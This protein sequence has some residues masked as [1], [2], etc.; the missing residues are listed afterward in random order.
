MQYFYYILQNTNRDSN[1]IFFSDFRK[2]KKEKCIIGE[3]IQAVLGIQQRTG[4][5]T[6]IVIHNTSVGQEIE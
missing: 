6:G 2:V 4:D 3:K 5:G 1:E